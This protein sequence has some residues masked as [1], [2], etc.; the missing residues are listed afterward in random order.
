MLD[1]GAFSAWNKGEIIPIYDYIDFI[2]EHHQYFTHIVCLDVIDNPILSEVNHLIMLKELN[3]Y[4]LTIIPV[5]HSGES[6]K[7][8][9]YMVEKGYRYIG[10][11]PNNNWNE[12]SKR[13]WLKR[14]FLRRDFEKL[15]IKTH[16]FGYQSIDGLSFIPLTTTDASTWR[17][18]AGY[19]RI[20]NPDIPSLRYSDRTLVNHID[21]IPGGDPKFVTELCQ[22][23]GIDINDLRTKEW[24]RVYFNTEA[25][26][27]LISKDK[28][29][30]S[31]SVELFEEE[32]NDD[33]TEEKVLFQLQSCLKM[34]HE[35]KGL[36]EVNNIKS[37]G[38][39]R[40]TKIEKDW[41]F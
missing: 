18:A 3:E 28:K 41:L 22:E 1:S 36:I 7:V 2:K 20:V 34:G 15:G 37:S 24:S 40:K 12:L 17:I 27:R 8:L 39:I 6:F 11:S 5:F 10:I 9:D 26:D 21:N 25:L 31:Y 29:D 33:F 32:K 13:S 35:Y 4:N 16:G 38:R 30:V 14:V 19:G 23:L